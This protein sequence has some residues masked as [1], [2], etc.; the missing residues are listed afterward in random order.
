MEPITELL[1]RSRE[2]DHAASEELAP[3]IYQHLH[4]VAEG[5]LRSERTDHTLTAT[6]L[7]N[8]VWIRIATTD[9][10]DFR[11]RNHF[12][13]MAARKMR[14]ILVDYARQRGSIKRGSGKRAPFEEALAVAS[15][16]DTETVL[17]MNQILDQLE[18]V[19][20]RRARFFELRFFAGMTPDEIA[21]IES[22]SAPTVYRE[23][24]LAQAWLYQK[25]QEAPPVSE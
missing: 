2:G 23:L 19:N 6:A 15:P 16:S 7:M 25:M 17:A 11:D 8:E 22:T 3:L 10:P 20:P 5:F 13:S 14:H 21:D 4:R 12:F 1:R 9:R 24:R 18:L